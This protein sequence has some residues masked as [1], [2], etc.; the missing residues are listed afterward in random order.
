MTEDQRQAEKA[1]LLLDEEEMDTTHIR[2]L[3][4]FDEA[5][6]KRDR[7]AWE[8][9]RNTEKRGLEE[10]IGEKKENEEVKEVKKG[11]QKKRTELEEEK[12]LMGWGA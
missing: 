7:E 8:K 1:K 4:G 3:A 2:K 12:I 11:H 6:A 10:L 5:K 9:A